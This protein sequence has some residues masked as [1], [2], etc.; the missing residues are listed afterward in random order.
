MTQGPEYEIVKITLHYKVYINKMH[1]KKKY[2]DWI[3]KFLLA[4]EIYNEGVWRFYYKVMIMII[5][6]DELVP[7]LDIFDLQFWLKQSVT[8][9]RHVSYL[10]HLHSTFFFIH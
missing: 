10:S 5:I 2:R 3:F 1:D 4:L 9:L 8:Q 6:V 7:I